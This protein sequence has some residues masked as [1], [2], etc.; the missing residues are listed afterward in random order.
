MENGTALVTVITCTYNR[1]ATLPRVYESLC[2]QTFT[3]FE[4]IISD[5]GSTDS[6]D[7]LVKRW[8]DEGKLNIVY[9]YQENNGKH[10][11]TNAAVQVAKGQYVVNMDSDDYMREDA[12]EVFIRTWQ[13]IP[14]EE[15]KHFFAV[16][17]RCYDTS[18]GEPIGKSVPGGRLV[19]N[20][21]DA[22]Y[23]Y[24]MQDEMWSMCRLE[25][26]K[27]YPNPD[28]R[29]GRDGGGLRFYPEGIGQD[30]AARKYKIL[31]IDDAL[32]AY[33]RS[34]STSLMGYGAK[35]DRSREN[36]FM[37]THIVNDNLDYFWY[38]PKSFIKAAVGVSMDTFLLKRKLKDTYRT[39]K[40][41]KQKLLVSLFVP[42]GWVCYLKRK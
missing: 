22:K 2:K 16:K 15:R 28:I 35:Y 5:D 30:L 25:A 39:L 32:R 14:E 6:T 1:V 7:E 34:A 27:E 8:I 4:W 21:L 17:A 26:V 20:F 13:S 12:L 3:D 11:A 41:F 24:K 29:G 37:W 18:T 42:I 38:D 10:I 23:K 9:L 36:I 19:C 33:T 40:G 31:L